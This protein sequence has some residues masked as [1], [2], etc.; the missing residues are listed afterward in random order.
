MG[1]KRLEGKMLL[2]LNGKPLIFWAW[3]RSVEAFGPDNVVVAIPD[4][5]ENAPLAA[6]CERIGA[7]FTLWDGPED[8]VLARFYWVANSMRWH[9]DSV[10]VRVTPDDPFKVPDLMRRV[11]AGERHPVELSCEAFTLGYLN[12]AHEHVTDPADRE[13]LT[14]ILGVVPPP[15]APP[16]IWSIDT[17]EDLEAARELKEWPNPKSKGPPY[18]AGTGDI[19]DPQMG[20]LVPFAGH[21]GPP[22]P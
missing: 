10:I 8:D 12:M 20:E 2:P 17:M 16:G 9:H 22:M 15:K 13:H 3:R 14:N 6:Y 4:T 7:N 1:S 11:A 5:P 18:G 19:S 21:G